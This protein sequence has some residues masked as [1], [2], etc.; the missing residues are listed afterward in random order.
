[1]RG[2]ARLI[3]EICSPAVVV[4]LLPFAVAWPATGHRVAPTAGWGLL[5]ATFSSVLPMA[6]IV[7]GA[8]RGEWEG[9]HIRNR[10]GRLVPL[11]AGL[12][13]TAVGLG[14][15]L[16]LHAPRQVI[17]LDVAMMVT[18]SACVLITQWWKISLHATVAGSA[19]AVLTL[20]YGAAMLGLLLVLLL[21]T[22]SRVRLA[23]HT[24]GQVVAG[25]V[26]GPV[27][28]GTVFLAIALPG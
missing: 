6:F 15:L 27:L 11:L 12:G 25:A 8:R 3:T 26:L 14:L 7:W 19:V 5:V 28:G 9:H 23:D 21:I 1:M 10:E 16:L 22:W 24:V 17:G 13:C 18:L 2:L 4:L 20:L